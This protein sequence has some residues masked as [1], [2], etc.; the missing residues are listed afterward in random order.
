MTRP[1]NV[2]LA[3]SQLQAQR[4]TYFAD[5]Q[6]NMALGEQI[7][8]KAQN[9]NGERA[10]FV[11]QYEN[12]TGENVSEVANMEKWKDRTA[13][14]AESLKKVAAT[15]KNPVPVAKIQAVRTFRTYVDFDPMVER[16]KVLESYGLLTA[17]K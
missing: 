17:G 12:A 15:A 7:S 2:Q 9:L 5:F 8:A 6:R 13:K 1:E 3:I 14:Q 10:E 16:N 11:A 4:Y